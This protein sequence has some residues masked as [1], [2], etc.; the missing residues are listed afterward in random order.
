M[1][2]IWKKFALLTVVGSVL[3][4]ALLAGCGGGDAEGT[5]SNNTTTTTKTENSGE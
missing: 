2:N 4:G 1:R 3:C 5:D